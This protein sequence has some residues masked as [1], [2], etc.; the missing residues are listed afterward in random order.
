MERLLE[1][2]AGRCKGEVV[3]AIL[4]YYAKMLYDLHLKI[5]YNCLTSPLK[6]PSSEESWLVGGR[7]PR[8]LSPSYLPNCSSPSVAACGG[9]PPHPREVIPMFVSED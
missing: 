9:R 4:F 3:I 7:S 5:F 6:K 8:P 2:T 1:G